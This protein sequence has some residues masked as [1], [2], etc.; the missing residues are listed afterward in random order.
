MVGNFINTVWPYLEIKEKNYESRMK[1]QKYISDN[2]VAVRHRICIMILQL[3]WCKKNWWIF[4]RY[5]RDTEEWATF[6]YLLFLWKKILSNV[7]WSKTRKKQR[8]KY[9]KNW[10]LFQLK[11]KKMQKYLCKDDA[12]LSDIE[13]NFV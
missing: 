10:F 13:T 5:V 1:I 8:V 2:L 6:Y 3:Y 11:W 7:K 12:H 4:V 9:M